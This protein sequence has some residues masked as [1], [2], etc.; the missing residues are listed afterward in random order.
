MSEAKHTPGPWYWLG[1]HLESADRVI[2][3]VDS[4]LPHPLDADLARIVQCVNS[5]DA[6]V[7]ALREMVDSH[8][9][10]YP[11]AEEGDEAQRKWVHRKSDAI[12]NARA[13][14]AAATGQKG[15]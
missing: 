11:S 13:A 10:L 14:I 9:A 5:H 3:S 7:A 2:L 6:L 12:D 4:D 8:T 1:L 15:E